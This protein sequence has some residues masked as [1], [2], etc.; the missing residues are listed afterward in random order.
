MKKK[1]LGALIALGGSALAIGS[2]FA[3]YTGGLPEDKSIQIGT[4]TTGDIELHGG[5][6]DADAGNAVLTP[7]NVQRTIKFSAGFTP[8][9]GSVY[10]QDYYLAKL[11]F[12][13][14]SA[15]TGL[16]D[17]LKTHSWVELGTQ[18]GDNAYGRYWGWSWTEQGERVTS[19]DGAYSAQNHL[20]GESKVVAQDGKS[21]SWST[22]YPLFKGAAVS[23]FL[24]HVNMEGIEK[25]DY[26]AIAE[27]SYTVDFNISEPDSDYGMAYVVG[28]A[29]GGWEDKDEYR[30][31]V[32][33]KAADAYEWI[34]KTGT[35]DGKQKLIDGGEYKLHIGD[36][37]CDSDSANHTWS[38]SNKGEAFTWNAATHKLYLGNTEIHHGSN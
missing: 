38:D 32:N 15:S 13:I 24:L 18:S 11:E 5:V 10:V 3:L 4:K 28:T 27:K 36:N 37:Y 16:I 17:A 9:E 14:S 19:G 35:E 21:V 12:K 26:K 25:D 30:M 2:A 34:F 22:H 29:T 7:D 23:Q 33:A 31:T 8:S 1:L 20:N 6:L